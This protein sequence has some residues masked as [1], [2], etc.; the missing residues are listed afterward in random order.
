MINI[1]PIGRGGMIWDKMREEWDLQKD[2]GYQ[3]LINIMGG[4]EGGSGNSIRN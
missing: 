3:L 1:I 2:N 4:E